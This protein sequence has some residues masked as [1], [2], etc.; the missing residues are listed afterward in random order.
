MGLIQRKKHLIIGYDPELPPWYKRVEYIKSTG[1]QYIIVNDDFKKNIQYTLVCQCD[2]IRETTVIIGQSARGG[3]WFGTSSDGFY[4]SG[5]NIFRN[6]ALTK[7]ITALIEYEDNGIYVEVDSRSGVS[8]YVG[9]PRELTIFGA[10]GGTMWF[11]SYVKIFS[12]KADGVVNLIPCYRISDGTIGMYDTVTRRFLTNS[13]TGTFI[14]G[15]E[16]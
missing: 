6:V 13:G 1:T 15:P 5:N 12:L 10:Q 14:K 11:Y 4:A 3:H 7:K 8:L 9:D 2:D 16:V